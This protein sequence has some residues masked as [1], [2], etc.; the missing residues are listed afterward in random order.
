ASALQAS[1]T[2][3]SPEGKPVNG[4]LQ[5]LDSTGVS[6][7]SY[8]WLATSCS[9]EDA[10][11]L[12]INGTGV[13]RVGPEPG[14]PHCTCTPS[15]G[16]HEV[17]LAD[18]LALLGPGVNQLGVRKT[19][20]LPQVG[21]TGL[22][23]AYATITV[24]GVAQRVDIFDQGGGNDFD[25]TDLCAAGYTFDAV[26][27]AAGSPSLPSPLVSEPGSPALPSILV[28]PPF[29]GPPSFLLLVPATAG[30][31]RSPAADLRG[32]DLASQSA[33]I[34]GGAASCDDGDPCTTDACAP[35][36]SG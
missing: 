11:D 36:T 26:D 28:P 3:T 7:L 20:G 23:W 5:V 10:F 8:T 6:S 24:G 35:G 14:G 30:V 31:V 33:M 32:F 34:L 22:A 9:G 25:S 12:T 18:A 2:R 1:I 19:T 16:S 29:P 13:A 4:V 21:R 17:P 27:A 15:V